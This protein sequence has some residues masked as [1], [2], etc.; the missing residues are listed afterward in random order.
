MQAA[1]DAALA[2][3]PV[4]AGCGRVVTQ[5][6]HGVRPPAV[7]VAPEG[8][9]GLRTGTARHDAAARGLPR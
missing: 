4:P 5:S 7:I 8:G 9:G 1:S 2:A 3:L 6:P